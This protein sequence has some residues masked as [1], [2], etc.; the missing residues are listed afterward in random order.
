M[1][2]SGSQPSPAVPPHRRTVRIVKKRN[3][4]RAAVV[5][6]AVA[7]AAAGLLLALW[8]AFQ[9]DE[10]P[11]PHLRTI[12]DVHVEWLCEQ[13]HSLQ[14]LGGVTPKPCWKCGRDS[15]PVAPYRC[16]VH[17]ICAVAFGFHE[18]EDG[19][20]VPTELRAPGGDW[21]PFAEGPHCGICRRLMTREV[22]DPLD[23]VPR[24]PTR[25]DGR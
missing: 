4:Q 24:K 18:Q 6:L 12:K 3:I 9:T 5:S 7:A 2:S 19:Q 21:E 23:R 16:P 20:I 8:R 1:P 13:G 25:R 14:G 11:R 10:V 17:G 22:E 15:Y